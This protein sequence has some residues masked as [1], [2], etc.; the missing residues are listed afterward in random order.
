MIIPWPSQLEA[1]KACYAILKKYG[2][3]YLAGEERTGKLIAAVVTAEM[4]ASNIEK[5]L[6][7]TTKKALEGWKKDLANYSTIKQFTATNYH[8]AHKLKPEY[9]LIIL[10]ECHNYLPGY[11]KR[12]DM[13]H[14][15]HKLTRGRPIIFSSA[16]PH[17][18]G[19]QQ[20]Y[21]QLALSTWSPWADYTN[22]YSWHKEYGIETVVWIRGI[23]KKQYHVVEEERI[24]EEV[25]HLFY[26]V[27]RSELGFE[28]EPVDKLHYIELSEMT[29]LAYNT[30]VQHKVLELRDFGVI[31]GDTPIKLRTLLHQMEGGGTKILRRDE[32]KEKMYTEPKVLRNTEKIDYIKATWGDTENLVIMF[33]YKSEGM[34]LMQ[35]F[36][37][38]RILQGTTNAEGLDLS[39]CEHL[40]IYS[41]DFSTAKHTQRRARQANKFRKTDIV[42]HYLLVKG[43]VS[44]QVYQAVSVNKVNFVDSVFEKRTLE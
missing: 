25:E 40:V 26:T 34:K 7:L 13:W 41:Q 2:I 31:M 18:Q 6:V 38:A 17:A 23:A 8:Q 44:E 12:S 15:V 28:K 32:V 11:P 14:D 33:Q 20:L 42:V 21:N 24:K 43:G 5:V 16:T 27:T 1:A 30:L 10:D 37:H 39:M 35:H 19:R 3:V 22:F 29:K 9:D 4:C 36:K